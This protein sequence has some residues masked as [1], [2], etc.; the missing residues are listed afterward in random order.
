MR[1]GLYRFLRSIVIPPVVGIYLFSFQPVHS[2][3]F[4]TEFNSINR[5]LFWGVSRLVSEYLESKTTHSVH[6]IRYTLCQ[7]T[8]KS[9]RLRI[10]YCGSFVFLYGFPTKHNRW[11]GA[12]ATLQ[13]VFRAILKPFSFGIHVR[14]MHASILLTLHISHWHYNLYDSILWFHTTKNIHHPA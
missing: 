13:L 9:T 2:I 7:S 1:F 14:L 6:W 5:L 12:I 10:K 3:F 11:F 8:S 4:A